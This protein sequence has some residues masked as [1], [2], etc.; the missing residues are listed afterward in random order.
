VQSGDSLYAIAT[1]FG[2]TINA[3]MAANNMNNYFIY[4]GMVL[5]IPVRR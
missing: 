3:I 1:R 5:R 4:K 2:T